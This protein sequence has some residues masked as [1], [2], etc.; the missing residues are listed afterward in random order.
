[1]HLA[2]SG[3]SEEHLRTYLAGDVHKR[4]LRR[5]KS[6]FTRAPCHRTGLLYDV[7][8]TDTLGGVEGTDSEES[9]LVSELSGDPQRSFC[10]DSPNRKDCGANY[11]N[12]REF[13]ET[14][15]K[16]NNIP[17]YLKRKII[18]NKE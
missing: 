15:F 13:R 2:S 10:L 7:R 17:N 8:A 5:P 4:S 14:A 18:P 6:A 16:G 1:M 3:V 9:S 11:W 12:R